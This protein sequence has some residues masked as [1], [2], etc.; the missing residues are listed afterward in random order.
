MISVLGDHHMPKSN[1]YWEIKIKPGIYI[2][3]EIDYALEA[4]YNDL[5]NCEFDY[6]KV[7][8]LLS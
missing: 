3:M 4:N 1:C 6:L 8:E 5:I 2:D 7:R